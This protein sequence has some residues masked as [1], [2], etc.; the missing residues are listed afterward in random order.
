MLF[1]LSDIRMFHNC[2]LSVLFIVP[3]VPM[4][5]VELKSDLHRVLASLLHGSEFTHSHASVGEHIKNKRQKKFDP[6]LDQ[7]HAIM[8]GSQFV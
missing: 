7:V 1:E 4:E 3:D 6:N 2:R 5:E 8:H